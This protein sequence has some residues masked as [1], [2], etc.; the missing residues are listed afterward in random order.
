MLWPTQLGVGVKS[1]VEVAIQAWTLR[2]RSTHGKVLA[3]LDF[4]NA[5]NRISRRA[6]LE[7]AASNFP[8]VS[9]WVTWCYQRPSSF[10]FGS[11]HIPSA[12][13]VQHGNGDPLGPL[14]FS[15]AIHALTTELK[16][17]PWTWQYST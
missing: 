3:K 1:G 8:S 9:R 17:G 11:S 16:S 10:C 12:G 15:T 2:R 13:G 14:L 6:V 7:M 5:F 4:A